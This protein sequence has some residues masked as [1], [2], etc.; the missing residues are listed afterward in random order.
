M[1]GI[2]GVIVSM[3]IFDEYEHS[4]KSNIGFY[5]RFMSGEKLK[6]GWIDP[7][8]IEPASK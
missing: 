1:P 4:T 7:D 3:P 2:F 5:E 6:A 8:D